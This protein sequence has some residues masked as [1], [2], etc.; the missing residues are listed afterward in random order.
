MKPA[1]PFDLRKFKLPT[2]FGLHI[3]KKIECGKA[4]NHSEYDDI[5]RSLCYTIIQQTH[6]PGMDNIR[7]IVRILYQKYPTL[8]LKDGDGDVDEDASVVRYSF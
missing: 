2:T 8:L 5:S 7:A 1:P 4:L 3:K 6:A